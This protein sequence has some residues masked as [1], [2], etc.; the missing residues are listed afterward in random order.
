MWS[1]P[2]SFD[3]CRLVSPSSSDDSSRRRTAFSQ[4]SLNASSLPLCIYSEGW[5]SLVC[6]GNR[7]ITRA[8]T[9]YSFLLS[10]PYVLPFLWDPGKEKGEKRKLLWPWNVPV[11]HKLNKKNLGGSW[12]ISV[13][14]VCSD[15]YLLFFTSNMWT[16]PC[17]LA[18]IDVPSAFKIHYEDF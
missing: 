8:K 1:G 5:L 15:F 9:E 16:V 12:S 11:L 13:A 2:A 6:A 18:N 3:S 7:F 4:N 17:R 14:C 10:C